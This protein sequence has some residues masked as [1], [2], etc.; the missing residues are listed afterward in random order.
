MLKHR[1]VAS[2][3][4]GRNIVRCWC[5]QTTMLIDAD[6]IPDLIGD[7][8]VRR[9]VREREIEGGGTTRHEARFLTGRHI[10][11]R[12]PPP[13]GLVVGQIEDVRCGGSLCELRSQ[14][15]QF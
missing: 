5:C 1:P 8:A 4:D 7:L 11:A 12:Q 14:Q 13:G 3:N 2:S 9:R 10:G 15:F 6:K